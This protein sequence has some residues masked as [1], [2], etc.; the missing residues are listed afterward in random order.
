MHIGLK[1][2]NEIPRPTSVQ[3]LER[4]LA[5]AAQHQD[6]IDNFL[7]LAAPLLN[8]RRKARASGKQLEWNELSEFTYKELLKK[9]LQKHIA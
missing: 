7:A 5:H 3:E 8:M 4:F 6:Y 2:L 1:H 9:M